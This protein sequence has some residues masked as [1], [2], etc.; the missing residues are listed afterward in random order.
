VANPGKVPVL[1]LGVSGDTATPYAWAQTIAGKLGVPLVTQDTTGHGVYSDTDNQC[2][3]DVVTGY[4][5][6][7]TLPTGPV[8]C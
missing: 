7:G 3:I 1:V 6:S 5:Q 2:T 8:T 4:L